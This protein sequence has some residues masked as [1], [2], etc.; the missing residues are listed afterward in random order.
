MDRVMC[1]VKQAQSF[2]ESPDVVTYP[3]KAVKCVKDALSGVEEFS[4]I[5][6]KV[7]MLG[8]DSRV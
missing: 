5:G 2:V 7:R 1:P 3:D 6:D 8:V 4:N